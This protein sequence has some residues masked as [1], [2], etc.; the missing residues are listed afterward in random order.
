MIEKAITTF[1]TSLLID[2]V[3]PTT[4][5]NL[6][7]HYY[8]LIIIIKILIITL[9]DCCTGKKKIMIRLLNVIVKS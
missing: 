5:S 2:Y 8:H 6:G 9:L 1:E 3:N 7:Y 4:H